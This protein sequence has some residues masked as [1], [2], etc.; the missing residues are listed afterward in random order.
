LALVID[1]H[2]NQPTLYDKE[3][4]QISD[5]KAYCNRSSDWHWQWIASYMCAIGDVMALCQA[6]YYQKAK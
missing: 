1:T 4:H 2:Q 3:I 6:V 5:E